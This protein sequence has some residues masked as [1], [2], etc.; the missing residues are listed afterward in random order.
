M[1]FSRQGISSA[2]TVLVLALVAVAL[3]IVVGGLASGFLS[4][5]GKSYSVSISSA[6][7]VRSRG[8]SYFLVFSVTNKGSEPVTINNMT[9]EGAG[10]P[11]CSLTHMKG[12]SQVKPSEATEYTYVC[13]PVTLG[14]KYHVRV[15]TVE[16]ASAWATVT[17]VG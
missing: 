17:A 6:Q 1:M 9:I 3:V 15:F 4:P 8:D 13:S 7:L 14:E 2:A 12:S 16:G 11:V 10:N 5:Y